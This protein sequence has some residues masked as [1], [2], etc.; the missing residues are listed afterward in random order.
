MP[1]GRP[2]RRRGR[3][4]LDPVAQK[5][6][7][8]T[9]GWRRRRRG[10]P[11][12]RGVNLDE[13]P[14][15]PRGGAARELV[16]ELRRTG[17]RSARRWLR[18]MARRVRKRVRASGRARG[19]ARRRAYYERR[20]GPPHRRE[21]SRG[22]AR[23]RRAAPDARPR[24]ISALAKPVA[25]APQVE[26]LASAAARGWTFVAG[27][28]PLLLRSDL[29]KAVVAQ[30]DP[31]RRR[32]ARSAP[33]E[34]Q[35]RRG[36]DARDR[37]FKAKTMRSADPKAKPRRLSGSPTRGNSARRLLPVSLRLAD[38]T[39]AARPPPHCAA[40]RP[41]RG[42]PCA[43]ARAARDTYPSYA[44]GEEREQRIV[45]ATFAATKLRLAG[46][47]TRRSRCAAAKEI[48]VDRGPARAREQANARRG[49]I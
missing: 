11:S 41:R 33:V 27:R 49:R 23:P 8:R 19:R 43:A 9:R 32:R 17:A 31:S 44:R 48:G 1:T 16:D 46:R 35:Q 13:E 30:R 6:A 15:R 42:W 22:R 25:E 14:P 7:R 40:P 29:R 36:R 3:A 20:L 4:R 26:A 45:K 34:T 39:L 2:A 21:K 24:Q 18:P 38:V 5:A 28:P 47:S 37:S 10:Q 12:P